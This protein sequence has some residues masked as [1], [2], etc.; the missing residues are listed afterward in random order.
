MPVGGRTDQLESRFAEPLKAIGRAARFESAA[1]N[2]LRPGARYDPRRS[3]DLFFRF[4]AAR[5]RHRNDLRAPDLHFA[6]LH[7]RSRRLEVAAGEFVGRNDAV[8]FFYSPENLQLRRIEIVQRT[9]ATEYRM[10]H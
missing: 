2:Y 6:E 8:T 5:A 7:N 1:A 3:L 9:H 4:N 10:A